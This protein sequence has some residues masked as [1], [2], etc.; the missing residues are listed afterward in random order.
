M[1]V[2]FI[3][4]LILIIFCQCILAKISCKSENN[5]DL[6]WYIIIKYPDVYN[7][8]Y[9]SSETNGKSWK[10]PN[11]ALNS[12]KNLVAL[13]LNQAYNATNDKSF[14]AFY[15][16]DKAKK[17]SGSSGGHLKGVVNFDK[18]T[19]YWLVHSV[20]HF[21]P[22]KSYNYPAPQS[23]NGQSFFCVSLNT[24][25]LN[26]IL[27]QLLLMYADVYSFHLPESFSDNTTLMYNLIKLIYNKHAPGLKSNIIN[28][29]TISNTPIMHF[30]K[31]SNF[32]DD[33]YAALIAPTLKDSLFVESWMNGG[34]GREPSN[35]KITYK[36]YNIQ[37][38]KICGVNFKE[39]QDHSKWAV[40]SSN[41]TTATCIGD[42][43]RMNTQ[44]FR[45]GGSLCIFQPNVWT[46]FY[47]AIT[48]Y[49]KCN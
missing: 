35:C 18:E 43:N 7:F 45:G 49:E 41:V 23:I 27:I 46:A 25:N 3:V 30:G 5:T 21:P 37:A 28:L 6:D 48:E 32:S 8:F 24:S 4:L 12:D 44:F 36:V 13:T 10:L 1:I 19:G 39:Y 33:L 40:S 20:P 22:P 9:L 31:S 15:N 2:K 17:R 42:I 34:G 14:Y 38:I 47:S 29:K 16:D 26:D 11:Y